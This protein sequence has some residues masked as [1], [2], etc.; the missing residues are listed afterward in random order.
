MRAAAGG[1]EAGAGT[2]EGLDAWPKM[3]NMTKPPI[4]RTAATGA[5][6]KTMAEVTLLGGGG[7]C[8]WWPYG[9]RV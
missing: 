3:R 6:V 1:E 5:I 9:C 2:A 8:G 7:C 4:S